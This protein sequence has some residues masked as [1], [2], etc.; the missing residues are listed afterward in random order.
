M[1]A[2]GVVSWISSKQKV[3]AS[4]TMEAK[5]IGC[6]TTTK[7]AIWLRNFIKG[8]LKVVDSVERPIN[9]YCDNRVV[10]FFSRNN[11]RPIACRLMDIKYLH[12]RDEVRKGLLNI[13]HVGTD[14]MTANPMTKGLA[15]VMFKKHNYHMSM[16]ETFDSVNE[17]E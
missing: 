11:K 6:Y 16:R 9:I 3:I 10:V 14:L 2:D 8:R 12:V 7:Q 17:K 15:V 13:E 4:S 5:F 1:L